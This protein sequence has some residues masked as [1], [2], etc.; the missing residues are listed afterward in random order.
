MAKPKNPRLFDYEIYTS[1]GHDRA[2]TELT[3]WDLFAAA[4]LAGMS[5]NPNCSGEPEGYARSACDDAD[6]MLEEREK[7]Q[8]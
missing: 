5:A 3:L 1:D 8:S 2:A 6:A 4:S 7:R